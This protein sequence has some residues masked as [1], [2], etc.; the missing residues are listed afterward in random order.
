MRRLPGGVRLVARPLRRRPHRRG[1]VP[2]QGCQQQGQVGLPTASVRQPGPASRGALGRLGYH[3]AVN[4]LASEG[5]E[6]S[7]TKRDLWMCFV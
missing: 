4:P 1:L 2:G 7:V 6:L 5:G 3:G